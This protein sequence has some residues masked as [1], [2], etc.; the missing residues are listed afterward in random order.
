[1]RVKHAIEQRRNVRDEFRGENGYSW[2]YCFVF[3]VYSNRDELT[4]SQEQ[5]NLK[6][7]VRELTKGGLETKMFFS[8]QVSDR[9]VISSVHLFFLCLSG[10][11]ARSL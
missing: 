4:E 9:D 7:V 8:A 3:K 2:D 1:V 5:W 11:F 6:Y 10:L